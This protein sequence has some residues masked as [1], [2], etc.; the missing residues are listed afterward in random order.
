[1][2][3]TFKITD[4]YTGAF[5]RNQTPYVTTNSKSNT[6]WVLGY[7]NAATDIVKIKS[8]A[9]SNTKHMMKILLLKNIQQKIVDQ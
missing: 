9:N 2:K 6:Y 3:Y 8:V 7:L 4:K 5:L 1:M